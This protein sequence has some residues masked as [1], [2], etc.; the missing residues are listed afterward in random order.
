MIRVQL[1]VKVECFSAKDNGLTKV[2]HRPELLG[3]GGETKCKAIQSARSKRVSFQAKVEC[4]SVEDNGFIEVI[5][6]PE[7]LVPSGEKQVVMLFKEPD[8]R[9][10]PCG[11]RSSA[12]RLRNMATSRS[13]ISPSCL[14]RV[15]TPS[16]RD[17]D[18]Q[19]VR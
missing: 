4:S 16:A 9:G 19:R 10:F 3:P 13:L 7:P 14:Y 12:S 8:R 17:Q 5:H 1:R 18:V 11:Q 15:E 6:R 2:L